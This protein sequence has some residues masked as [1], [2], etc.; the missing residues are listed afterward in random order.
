M[1]LNTHSAETRV[2]THR[3]TRTDSGLLP[4]A[5]LVKPHDHGHRRRHPI[6]LGGSAVLWHAPSTH[7]MSDLWRISGEIPHNRS[8][9][10]ARGER[11]APATRAHTRAHTRT[12]Q[13]RH[14]TSAPASCRREG[15]RKRCGA[16]IPP[17]RDP[18]SSARNLSRLRSPAV[19]GGFPTREQRRGA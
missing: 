8:P 12:Q 4:L 7:R 1:Y 9:Q 6:V 3:Q 2:G 15:D 11:H 16:F 19:E 17:P 10:H 5:L 13:M 14:R 18:L